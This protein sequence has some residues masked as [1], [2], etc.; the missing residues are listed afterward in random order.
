LVIYLSFSLSHACAR[1]YR[2]IDNGPVEMAFPIS[3]EKHEAEKDKHK[4][5]KP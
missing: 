2:S 1:D 4:I 5:L 3:C